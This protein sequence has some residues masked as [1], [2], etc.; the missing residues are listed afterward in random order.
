MSIE[1]LY[2]G[3]KR[4][5]REVDHSRLFIAYVKNGWFSTSSP[6]IYQYEED[7]FALH[8]VPVSL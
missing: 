2:R 7:S 4:P 3:V 6:P 1:F 8:K 5:G